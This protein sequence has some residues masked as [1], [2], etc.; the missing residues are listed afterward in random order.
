MNEA[1]IAKTSYNMALF[2]VHFIISSML[3]TVYKISGSEGHLVTLMHMYEY[4]PGKNVAWIVNAGG[5][6]DVIEI[7]MFPTNQVDRRVQF[8]KDHLFTPDAAF[9]DVQQSFT[10]E[11]WAHFYETVKNLVTLVTT[12]EIPHRL[13]HKSSHESG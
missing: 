1:W 4:T 12:P 6:A 7:T 11:G 3:P 5:S 9:T 2:A 10:P 13:F 8:R